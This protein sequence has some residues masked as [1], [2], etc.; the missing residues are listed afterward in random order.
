MNLI[1][2]FLLNAAEMELEV[3]QVIEKM[4]NLEKAG[5]TVNIRWRVH[6]GTGELEFQFYVYGEG[7]T[8]LFNPI[9]KLPIELYDD[10]KE[11]MKYLVEDFLPKLRKALDKAVGSLLVQ[12]VIPESDESGDAVSNR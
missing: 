3:L 1:S 12:T 8:P 5:L 11:Q 6:P 2:K 9:I 10:K 4:L 7:E